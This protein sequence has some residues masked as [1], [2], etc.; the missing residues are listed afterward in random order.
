MSEH[1]QPR[2]G[3]AVLVYR[4]KISGVIRARYWD[5]CEDIQSMPDYE[6]IASLDPALWI[7]A[8]WTQVESG[9]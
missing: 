4:N 8:H 2:I 1:Q 6:H 3:H 5:D 9:E 7:A